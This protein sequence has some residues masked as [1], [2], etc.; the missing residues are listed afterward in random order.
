[1]LVL[2]EIK[3]FYCF[4]FFILTIMLELLNCLRSQRLLEM[5]LVINFVSSQNK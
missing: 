3:H 2:E 1:M 5:K 4:L